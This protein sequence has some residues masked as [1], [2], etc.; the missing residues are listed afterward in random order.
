MEQPQTRS[1]SIHQPNYIP[2]LGYFYKIY[3]TDYFVFLDD[4]QFSN[5]GMHNYHYI[6]TRNGS[7]RIKIPVFQ[8]LGDK[9]CE[10]RI[11]NEFDWREKHLY[12]LKDNYSL[13][14]HFTEV[15]SDFVSLIYENHEFLSGLNT[16]II[17]FFCNKLGIETKFVKS[18]DLNIYTVRE[19]KIIDICTALQ[20][21]LYLSGTGA[22]AY[23]KEEHF[24]EKGIR[25]KYS[26]YNTFPYE[27]QFPGFRS[28]VTI[29]D[30]L[31]NCGYNWDLVLKY[32]T[33][34]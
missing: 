12:M 20:C 29:L 21:D 34:T 27:Q 32:Q 26:E 17:K 2:W 7:Q 31:M 23:Q 30:Y 15:F 11:K 5:E 18:S 28:N 24:L 14:R 8:T 22:G 19:A 25:L 10:V 4:A 16:S 33:H 9:I 13:T 6:K 1:V 3:Q